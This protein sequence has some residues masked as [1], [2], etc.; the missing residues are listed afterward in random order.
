[1]Q[2]INW[3]I[4]GCV[5]IKN[6]ITV[7]KLAVLMLLLLSSA[8]GSLTPKYPVVR[9]EKSP[10]STYPQAQVEPSIAINP[11]NTSELIAGS[12]LNDYYYS[13]DGG[14]SW[15][16]KI[17]ESKYGVGGDPVVHIDAK[18]RYYYVHLSKPD[19]GF[20]LD[21]IVC[22]YTDTI[23]GTHWNDRATKPVGV[24]AQDKPWIVEC[25]KTGNLYLTW[26]QF[27]AYGSDAPLD[28]SIIVFS[29][30]TDQGNSWSIPKR[31]SKL[32]GDCLDG[33]DTV[34]GAVPAVNNEGVIFVTWTGPHGIRVNKS[35]DFGET[36]LT[37]EQKVGAHP[38]GWS[39]A[40]P[41]IYRTNGLP[42]SK[43]DCSG[44]VHDGRIYVNWSDQR[45]GETDTDVW[46]TYSDD[47]GASWESPIRVN[48]DRSGNHQFFTW[49][50]IDQKTGILYFVYYDR[51][52]YDDTQTDVYL[53]Y[54]KNGGKKIKEEKLNKT[55]FIPNPDIFFGDYINIAAHNGTVRP[56]WCEMHEGEIRLFT[57]LVGR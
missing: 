57:S 43:V 5:P 36:W 21:R 26:T 47:D 45:N 18:G 48:Q 20:R 34:E 16:S 13:T 25:P 28:S 50:D 44:G 3:V 19:D 30:S 46:L 17:L 42:I 51:R 9:I 55:P 6:N 14:K 29:K 37:E 4:T 49:M 54:S 11:N 39:F 53:A 24:K 23:T 56:I 2:K 12:V 41:G 35:E 15:T 8:C 1:M 38:G 22:Q 40:I 52:N 33:D 31:I 7:L 10:A 27:D 32:A